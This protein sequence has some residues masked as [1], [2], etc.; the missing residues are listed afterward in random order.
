MRENDLS[1]LIIGCAI[2]VHR[3]LG[4]GLLES[5]Y[6]HC[7]AFEL[8]KA[9]VDIRVQ[10]PLPV[11]YKGERLDLGFRLDIWVDN[12]VVVEVKAVE[13][14]N[15]VH[16]AQILT[17]LKLVDNRLGLL[18]NFNVARLKDGLKRVVLG[19]PEE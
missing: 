8:I 11:N 7:L 15:E 6:Q 9:G 17:Y 19:L 3:E 18:I 2:E 14:L 1:R 10:H 16:M 12:K 4:P 13:A 5:I